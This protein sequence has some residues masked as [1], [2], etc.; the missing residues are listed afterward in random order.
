MIKQN[1]KNQFFPAYTFGEPNQP[2]VIANDK[3]LLMDTNGT[4]LLDGDV[5][6]RLDLLPSPHIRF[7]FTNHEKLGDIERARLI[8]SL[9]SAELLELTNHERRIKVYPN[10]VHLSAS[11]GSSL[12]LGADS[13]TIIG[14]G[15]NTT[16][17]HHIVFHLFN[18]K[19]ILG[20]SFTDEERDTT[21]Y[22]IHHVNLKTDNWV[23][24]LRSLVESD[25]NFKK[26]K[27]EGGYGL[28]HIGYLKKT[29]DDLFSGRE[30]EEMLN[31]LG[32]FFSFAKGT[33]CNPIC[34]VGF[35]SSDNRVWESW[36]SPKESWSYTTSWF[37]TLHPEQLDNLF[38]GF[39]NRL[40]EKNWSD[41]FRECI[42]W[43]LNVNIPT[44]AAETGIILTQC[45]NEL[46]SFEYST[47]ERTLINVEGF[48][49]LEA[50]NK[51][52]LLFSSLD[53]PIGI[54]DK[55]PNLK[56]FAKQHKWED[57]PRAITEVRNSIIHPNNKKHGKFEADVVVE[58]LNLSLWFL[59]LS[60]LRLCGY[61]ENYEDRF[62]S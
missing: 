6:V 32:L 40:A 58:T 19:E 2:A 42:Y 8:N 48:T 21:T 28:T 39:L 10:N 52:R 7:Y 60:L 27:N 37:N 14:V 23:V 51:F 5:E 12:I 45:A 54:S 11:S 24:E 61:S 36:S 33:W 13:Q 53:I 62:T 38:S 44:Q 26:L 15:E 31:D 41:S 16:E 20:M 17:I 22:V 47:K 50:S 55:Y 57:A 49:K 30:A 29:S 43:Y 35:D 56:K 59:E 1:V 34:A 3:A 25:S 18:F 9:R 4:V 46:L